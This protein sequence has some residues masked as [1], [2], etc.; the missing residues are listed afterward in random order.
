M[1]PFSVHFENPNFFN[2]PFV[3]A[4][5]V[6]GMTYPSSL[7]PAYENRY[8]INEVD[9]RAAELKLLLADIDSNQPNAQ[10]AYDTFKAETATAVDT[11]MKVC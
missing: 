7:N 3:H 8:S 4:Q 1:V 2:S 5:L 9:S 6:D 11:I 10:E